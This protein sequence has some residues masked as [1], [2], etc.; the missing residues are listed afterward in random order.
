MEPEWRGALAEQGVVEGAQRERSSLLLLVILP[1]LQEHQLADAVDEIG[2]I[3]GA[4]FG[5]AARAALFHERLLAKESDALLDG[6]VLGME[7]D[8]DDK[9]REANERFGQLPELDAVILPQKARFDHHLLAVMC[10][11]LDEGG[12]SKH[13]R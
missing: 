11:S 1:E 2:R 3:E 4:A 8:A 9:A 12:G 7:P 10:P 13:D 6:H 5:L